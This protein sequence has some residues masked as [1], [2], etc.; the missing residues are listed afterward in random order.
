MG[1]LVSELNNIFKK[2]DFWKKNVYIRYYKRN[3]PF[4][5]FIKRKKKK[6]KKII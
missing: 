6:K 1:S 3:K 5:L 2:G 4:F